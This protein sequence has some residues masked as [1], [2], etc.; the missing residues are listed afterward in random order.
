MLTGMSRLMF[1]ISL[2]LVADCAH[3]DFTFVQISD[4]HVG[5]KEAAF[6]ARYAEVVRQVNALKPDF[7]I[8][9]G[10]ALTIWSP[11]NMVPFKELSKNLAMPMH[12]IP[13]NHD[14]TDIAK[15]TA[16]EAN[17]RVQAWRDA[18]GYD[19]ESFEHQGC[20]FIG[21]DSN[22]YNSKLPE[23]ARQMAWLKSQLR[24]SEGKRVFIFQHQPL[25]LDKPDEPANY[26]VVAEP[27]RGELLKLFRQ[28]KVEAVLT[29]HLHRFNEAY[30]DKISFLSTPATSFSCAADKG[31]TGYR[32]FHVTDA[33]FSSRFVDM[34]TNGSPAE[35]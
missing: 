24:K 13:G 20:V 35:F 26:W 4:T 5:V 32:V 12:L 30:F 31:L 2:L 17:A 19:H 28:Y 25:F 23:E 8:H 3:A 33:G 1:A 34:R 10:D 29:G 15:I 14:I 21:L 18:A 11:E 22:L 6:N 9:T 16:D 27:A 7:V